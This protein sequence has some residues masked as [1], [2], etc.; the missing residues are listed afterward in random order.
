[1]EEG[2]ERHEREEYNTHFSGES[3]TSFLLS[4]GHTERPH[5][6]PC[7]QLRETERGKGRVERERE[8]KGEREREKGRE[9]KRERGKGRERS[10]SRL[11]VPALRELHASD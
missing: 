9:D 2:E 1:M 4:G 8:G 11:T 10:R 3:S 5:S 7:P 6:A